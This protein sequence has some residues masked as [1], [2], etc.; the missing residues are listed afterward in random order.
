M[1]DAVQSFTKL[2]H[3]SRKTV[4]LVLIVVLVTIITTTTI[5][6]LLE[7]TTH[8]RFPSFGTIKTIG[9][10]AYWDQ[11]LENKTETID[12]GIVW[13]GSSRNVTF[14]VRS[15]CSVE[16]TL[17]LTTNN[18]TLW[19][20]NRKIV[21]EPINISRYMNLTWNY[22]GTTLDPLDV[23][24]VTLTLSTSYSSDFISVLINYDV[25]EFSFDIIISTRL[26]SS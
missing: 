17:N 23:I 22:N 6:I 3:S 7:K 13:L 20:A 25:R 15:I 4:L 18:W 2:L 24:Q 14:Y 12:W 26:V 16:T 10:E 5:S 8:L 21:T 1:K 19:D 11:S 9:V